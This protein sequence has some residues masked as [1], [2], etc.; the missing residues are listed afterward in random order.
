[1]TAPPTKK[2]K[3]ANKPELNSLNISYLSSLLTSYASLLSE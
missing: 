3:E 2:G 1:M